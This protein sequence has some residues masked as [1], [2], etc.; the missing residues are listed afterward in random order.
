MYSTLDINTDDATLR[1]MQTGTGDPIVFIHGWL[2]SGALFT[3]FFPDFAALG[4][5]CVSFD[6][7]GFGASQSHGN[8]YNYDVFAAALHDVLTHLKLHHITLIGFS[9]GSAIAVR[10]LSSYGADRIKKIV[11]LAPTVPKFTRTAEFPYGVDAAVCK[12]LMRQYRME[13]VR[14][15]RTFLAHFCVTGSK[16]WLQQLAD[17]V[18][19]AAAYQSLLALHDTDLRSEI[20]SVTRPVLILQGAEDK[21]SP[22]ELAHYL[23]DCLRDSTI[24]IFSE[25]GHAL[26][27]DKPKLFIKTLHHFMISHNS[28]AHLER[29]EVEPSLV[30]L[31]NVGDNLLLHKK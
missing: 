22:N 15:A 20:P 1:V 8:T 24:G 30:F 10:Y 29:R 5:R 3:P 2:V 11:L 21:I 31:N 7:P 25:A 18:Q 12:A 13:P 16:K 9:M 4:Y 27:L 6:L 17:L 28:T 19:P 14:A 23:Q 26:F